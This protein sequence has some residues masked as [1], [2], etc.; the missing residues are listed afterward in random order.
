MNKNEW[1]DLYSQYSV[2]NSEFCNF[3]P[4]VVVLHLIWKLYD[5]Y[6]IRLYILYLEKTKYMLHDYQVVQWYRHLLP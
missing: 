5:K 6:K 2:L 1:N 4:T 3:F